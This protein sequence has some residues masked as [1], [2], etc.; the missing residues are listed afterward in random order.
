MGTH[1][2]YKTSTYVWATDTLTYVQ[3]GH[4]VQLFHVDLLLSGHLGDRQQSRTL[5]SEHNLPPVGLLFQIC[6][7]DKTDAKH[8]VE[9]IQTYHIFRVNCVSLIDQIQKLRLDLASIINT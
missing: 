3:D 4:K 6:L 7:L 9:F 5:V 8:F 1:S 2:S